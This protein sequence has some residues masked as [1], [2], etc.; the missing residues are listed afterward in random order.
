LPSPGVPAFQGEHNEEILTE[1]QIAPD[2]IADMR[3]RRVLLSRRSPIG[4]FD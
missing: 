1:R 3:K 4:A 2:K